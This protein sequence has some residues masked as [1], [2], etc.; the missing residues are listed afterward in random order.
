MKKYVEQGEELKKIQLDLVKAKKVETDLKEEMKKVKVE[1]NRAR[2]I[3]SNYNLRSKAA[4]ET[5]KK[6]EGIV[7]GL[8]KCAHEFDEMKKYKLLA[9]KLKIFTDDVG[10]SVDLKKDV[11]KDPEKYVEM[12]QEVKKFWS[13]MK[14]KED[15]VSD[16]MVMNASGFQLVK[17][18]E[19]VKP[20]LSRDVLRPAAKV[21]GPSTDFLPP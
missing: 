6:Y 7:E 8:K 18:R 19:K 20:A 9:K 12:F 5:A 21:L 2:Q 4:S 10:A 17:R 1:L 16:E 3:G 13:Y 15:E 14:R 11:K